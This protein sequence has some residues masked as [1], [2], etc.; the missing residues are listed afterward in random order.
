MIT[1]GFSPETELYM[2]MKKLVAL[3]LLLCMTAGCALADGFAYTQ[4]SVTDCAQTRKTYDSFYASGELSVL[5]PG[6]KQGFVPQG[7]S[8]LPGQNW[9]IIAGYSGDDGVNSTIFAVDAAT[10]AFVKEV[11]LQYKDGRDY[12]GHAGGVAV[13]EKNIFIANNE[14]LYRISLEKFLALPE[15][16]HCS[17]DEEIPVPSR[18]SYCAYADGMLWVGEFQYS[19]YPTDIS[20]RFKTEDGRHKA[21]LIGYKLDQTTENELSAAAMAGETATPDVILTTTER[22]QGMTIKDGAVYLSQSYGRRNSATLYKYTDPRIGDPAAYQE[23]N[24]QQIPLWPLTSSIM[25]GTLIMPPMSECVC[26]A[27][28]AVYVLFES[29]AEKYMNPKDPAENP[30][31]RLFKI[32]NF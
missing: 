4:E 5:V 32:N 12:T 1:L 22:I 6:L 30:M 28:G 25:E 10:G 3:I 26:T 23:L 20:H 21:W 18:A 14:H 31:D 29:G 27:E 24:G 15:S 19:G 8:Y 11:H 2:N 17:F 7:L 9:F 13:T 16:S